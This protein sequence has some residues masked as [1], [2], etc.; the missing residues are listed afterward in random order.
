MAISTFQMDEVWILPDRFI[1][2]LKGTCNLLLYIILPNFIK[3]GQELF[4]II[5]VQTHTSKENELITSYKAIATLIPV[6]N[7]TNARFDR[8]VSLILLIR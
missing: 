6:R 7:H 8:S 3:I 2:S 4:E 1:P 5:W